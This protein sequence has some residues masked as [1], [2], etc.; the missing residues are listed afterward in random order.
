MRKMSTYI[1]LGTLI[2]ALPLSAET[3]QTAPAP[4]TSSP[5]KETTKTVTKN[6]IKP[7]PFTAFTGKITRNKVRLRLQPNLDGHILRELKKGDMLVVIGEQDDY[8]AVQPTQDQKAYIFRTF[9]L[10]NTVEGNHVNV[11]LEPDV[12]APIVAQLNTGDRVDG[13]VSPQNSK[14]L[15]ITPPSSARYYIS[16]EYV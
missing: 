13:K 10:D 11:R 1:A 15:E 2:L 5:K 14:W 16:K 7:K 3:Q 12:D 8:Y 4:K 6:E 9:V